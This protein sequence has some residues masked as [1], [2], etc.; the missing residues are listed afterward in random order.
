VDFANFDPDGEYKGRYRIGRYSLL[1]KQLAI[2]G[3]QHVVRNTLLRHLY[4]DIDMVNAHPSIIVQFFRYLDI[5]HLRKHVDRR[6]D[7]FEYFRQKTGLPSRYCKQSIA[8][9]TS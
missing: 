7:S 2:Q 8:F 4:V 3:L 9:S 5:R 6:A 1:P